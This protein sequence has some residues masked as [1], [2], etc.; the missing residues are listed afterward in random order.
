MS[1]EFKTSEEDINIALDFLQKNNRGSSFFEER[2]N[3]AYTMV[4]FMDPELK[5]VISIL[6]CLDIKD[7]KINHYVMAQKF[8]KNRGEQYFTYTYEIVKRFYKEKNW[9][10]DARQKMQKE[11]PE[12]TEEYISEND[13]F[14]FVIM[15]R[16]CDNMF[17]QFRKE[18][19]KKNTPYSSCITHAYDLAK[20]AHFWTKR[21]TGEPYMVH[22][23]EVAKILLNVDLEGEIIAAALLHDVIEDTDIIK[24]DITRKFGGR[25]AGLVDA[26]TSVHRE[27][28]NSYEIDKYS[29]DK[30][31]LDE[32]SFE[33]LIQAVQSDPFK[34]SALHIKA[35][36]RIHNLRT[37][38]EMSSTKK[39]KKTDETEINYLP[40]FKKFNLNYFVDIIEDLVWR[41]NNVNLYDTINDSYNTLFDYSIDNINSIKDT[42][43]SCLNNEFK[44]LCTDNAVKGFKFDVNVRKYPPL[45]IKKFLDNST[46]SIYFDERNIDKANMPLCDINVIM[47]PLDIHSTTDL[48]TTF[49]VKA[50]SMGFSKKELTIT[51][52][53]IDDYRRVIV[54]IEDKNRN[55]VRFSFCMREDYIIYING[56]KNGSVDYLTDTIIPKENR[57]SVK[58]RN[59]S[60]KFMPVG[61]TVLD[62][63]FS[64]HEEVGLSAKTS[65]INGNPAELYSILHE[66]DKVEVIS[67]SEEFTPHARI[68][69]LKHITTKNARDILIRYLERRYE[70]DNYKNTFKA[71]NNTIDNLIDEL[72]QLTEIIDMIN[73]DKE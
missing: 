19:K 27:Y 34:I 44:K 4:R 57:I 60:I 68:G 35:A 11:D 2:I 73:N 15:H 67:D 48:F 32:Y 24:D 62:L 65:I 22:P 64:I 21:K 28:Q 56:S 40:L 55:T 42:V 5:D 20:K 6:L 18:V 37:I 23:F 49:F 26:V 46:N 58:L 52:M 45:E 41:T 8:G 17:D 36:D 29:A 47:L 7:H 59:G 10:N 53:F 63:A 33:K 70:D 54:C 12:A 72:C 69:W 13:C 31:T 51:D 39:H 43:I 16:V 66:G 71:K 50:Y 61:S 38:D 9:L 14:D 1:A 30:L 25:I 3:S